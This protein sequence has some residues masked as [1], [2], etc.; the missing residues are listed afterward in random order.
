L[1]PHT[2]EKQNSAMLAATHDW[3]ADHCRLPKV[4][5]NNDSSTAS[6]PAANT[7][8][9]V[10]GRWTITVAECGYDMLRLAIA[11]V[12]DPTNPVQLATLPDQ[13]PNGY[14]FTLLCV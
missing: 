13:V 14:I 10:V 3:S 2:K 7:R 8:E 4:S 6:A 1:L 11:S 5:S 9:F 12:A